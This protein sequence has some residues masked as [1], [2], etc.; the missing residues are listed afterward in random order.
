MNLLPPRPTIVT[1]L[2]ARGATA[3]LGAAQAEASRLGVPV[4]VA[5]VDGAGHL[6]AFARMDGALRASIAIACDKAH[7]AAL[8]EQPTAELAAKVLPGEPLFGM[9]TDRFLPIA[10][11]VPLW[12][13]QVLV[14]A[15]GV[16]S[17]TIAQDDAI[18]RAGAAALEPKRG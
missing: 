14:G 2:G 17:A 18:A 10:G 3:V 7:T 8:F 13:D 5:V 12:M 15:I 4:N 9:R 11:G 16:S 6:S 1:A